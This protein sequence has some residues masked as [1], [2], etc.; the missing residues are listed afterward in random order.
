MIFLNQLHY[1]R[2]NEEV[3]WDVLK[4]ISRNLQ[5]RDTINLI[6]E[7]PYSEA[8]LFN[9]YLHSEDTNQLQVVSRL[10]P[11]YWLPDSIKALGIP[12]EFFGSDFEYSKKNYKRHDT[13]HYLLSKCGRVLDSFHISHPALN[14][15]IEE[16]KNYSL[17]NSDRIKAIKELK[18]LSAL[19][20]THINHILKQTLFSL[21]AKQNFYVNRDKDMFSGT[22]AAERLGLFHSENRINLFIMGSAHTN[23]MFRKSTYTYFQNN[24]QSN[25]K[26]R[27]YFLASVYLHCLG[28]K[29]FTTGGLYLES[30]YETMNVDKIKALPLKK[31][32]V[33][34]I[35]NSAEYSWPKLNSS[36]ILGIFVHNEITQIEIVN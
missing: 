24:E 8:V 36:Q 11:A 27:C 33:T 2:T 10:F 9:D 20:N 23:P 35:L 14:K 29:T 12:V 25:F 4:K 31:H 30:K 26:G 16:V 13:Y 5:P 21:N 1:V 32:A 3:Y 17:K 34:F 18:K 22:M 28:Y 7:S 15:V 6:I 19:N